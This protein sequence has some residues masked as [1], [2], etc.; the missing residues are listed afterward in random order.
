V[1]EL[2]PQNQEALGLSIDSRELITFVGLRDARR[3]FGEC[4]GDDF[5]FIVGDLSR[6][7]VK[8]HKIHIS[9]CQWWSRE[10]NILGIISL[11]ERGFLDRFL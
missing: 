4:W 7:V 1:K 3:A 6:T 2:H 5:R 11:Q 10:W 8:L 9:H